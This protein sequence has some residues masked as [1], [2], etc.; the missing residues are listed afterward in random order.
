MEKSKIKK[1]REDKGERRT[2]INY[3]KTGEREKCTTDKGK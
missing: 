2:G 1:I 3:K